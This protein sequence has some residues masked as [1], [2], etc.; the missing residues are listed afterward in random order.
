MKR[1]Q[2][3]DVVIAAVLV[4]LLAGFS[5]VV[6]PHVASGA[7]ATNEPAYH[8]YNGGFKK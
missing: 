5:A 2:K 6:V 8:N 1:N 3:G 4:Y 7:K